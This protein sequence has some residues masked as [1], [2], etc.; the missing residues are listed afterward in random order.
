MTSWLAGWLVGSL[1]EWWAK[2]GLCENQRVEWEPAK[3]MD[4][5]MKGAR[6]Y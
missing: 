4:E 3:G 2:S 5:W 6:T 1:N